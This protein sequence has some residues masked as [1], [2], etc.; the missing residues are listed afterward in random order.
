M[1]TPAGA[2]GQRRASRN[3]KAVVF[4]W[5]RAGPKVS[6]SLCGNP[7]SFAE[8]SQDPGRCFHE[9]RRHPRAQ[10]NLLPQKQMLKV[11]GGKSFDII[12]KNDDLE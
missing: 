1:P 4:P 11:K 12:Y 6:A 3:H 9:S 10:S 7:F 5:D 2:R 8:A